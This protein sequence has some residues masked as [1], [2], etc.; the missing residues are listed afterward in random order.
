[1]APTRNHKWE[2]EQVYLSSDARLEWPGEG[3][4]FE[5]NLNECQDQ[6]MGTIRVT[7]ELLFMLG[8]R[9]LDQIRHK[10]KSLSYVAEYVYH[11]C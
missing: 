5:L 6:N 8:L 10:C 3:P 7:P 11:I 4:L 9:P 1:M 2:L